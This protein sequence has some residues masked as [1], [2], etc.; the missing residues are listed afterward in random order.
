DIEFIRHADVNGLTLGNPWIQNPS[1]KNFA[2]RVG[3]AWDIGG[4]GKTAI[5]GGAGFFFQ[6]F[7]QSWYR[8]SGFRTPPIL[9]EV[10]TTAGTATP[11]GQ[12]PSGRTLATIPFPNIYQV[13]S[14]QNPFNSTDARCSARPVPDVVANKLRTPY[15]IQYNLNIQREILR[16]TVAIIGYAG[17][18]GIDLSGVANVSNVDPV[19]INGRLVFTGQQKPNPNFDTIRLR[20]TGYDSWYSSLQLSVMHRYSQGLQMNGSY[21]LAKN[22]DTISGNQTSS[23]TN[24]GPN[25]IP[26]YGWSHLYK[27]PSS[28]DTR[29][30]FSFNSTYDLPIG[31]G[32]VFGKGLNGAGRQMLAGWQLGGIVSLRSGFAESINISNRLANFGVIEELPDLASGASNN[33]IKGVS[34]GCGG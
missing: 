30:V 13:C 23:D 27:G 9:V 15:V 14:P 6:Q 16:D 26:L 3:F 22:L 1:L 11:I 18:R 34:I 28:F 32:K 25:T 31:P 12:A 29:H 8:T 4:N 5:R 24:A 2:P 7:D 19:A 10:E 17:S 20:H 21:T 33:P